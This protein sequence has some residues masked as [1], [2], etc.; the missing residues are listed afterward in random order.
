MFIFEQFVESTKS[1]DDPV[2]SSV[3]NL[4][5]LAGS[6]SGSTGER[7]LEMTKINLSLFTLGKVIDQLVEQPNGHIS[8]RDSQ[9]TKLL[10][11]SLGG[12]S[13]TVMICTFTSYAGEET[14]KTL[15]YVT[16][17]FV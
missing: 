10:K 16:Y 15:Q 5:D 9:L 1:K 14:A 7:F 4:V 11:N 17:I 3:L 13:M 6:E 8:Y 12:N 2:L